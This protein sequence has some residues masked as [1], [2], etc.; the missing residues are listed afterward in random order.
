VDFVLADEPAEVIRRFRARL[1]T[2]SWPVP[3]TD[4]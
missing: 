3:D 1:A 4:P 2:V